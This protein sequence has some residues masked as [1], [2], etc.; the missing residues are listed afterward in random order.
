MRKMKWHRNVLQYSV[1]SGYIIGSEIWG[2][3]HIFKMM[4]NT[5]KV[6]KYVPVHVPTVLSND[7]HSL[8]RCQKKTYFEDLSGFHF[9]CISL[10]ALWN[11]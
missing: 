11:Y 10:S 4:A 5:S 7:T 3:K 1:S 9:I 8:P 2:P 6:S